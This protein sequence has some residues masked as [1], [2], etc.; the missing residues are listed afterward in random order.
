MGATKTNSALGGT[1]YELFGC[2]RIPPV[3][4]DPNAIGKLAIARGS[5]HVL[6]EIGKPTGKRRFR[7]TASCRGRRFV[8]VDI[9][10]LKMKFARSTTSL[11]PEQD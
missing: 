2:H 5:D 6:I 4:P 7:G 8:C 10:K 11:M 1:G 9:V 3:R